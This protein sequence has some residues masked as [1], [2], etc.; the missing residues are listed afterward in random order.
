MQKNKLEDGVQI[1]RKILQTLIVNAVSSQAQVN[2]VCRVG[3]YHT[4]YDANYHQAKELIQT[5]AQ[6]VLAMSIELTRREL[7]GGTTDLSSFSDEDKKRALELSAYFTVPAIEPQHQTLAL[8]TAMNF[9][10]KN[11]Q[12]SSALNFANA[13]IERGTNARFKENVSFDR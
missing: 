8:F 6:Y 11:K 10:H 2:E 3:T 12:L 5:A 7:V 13:L 1:F 4:L 9:A